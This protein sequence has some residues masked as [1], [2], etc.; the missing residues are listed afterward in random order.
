DGMLKT[1][2]DQPGFIRYG[3]AD[4]GDKSCMSITLWETHEQAEASVPAAATWVK[5][6]IGDR[7]ELRS[8]YVGDLAFYEGARATV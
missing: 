7:V 3:V 2:K 4:I 8:S 6:N 1:F 5:E